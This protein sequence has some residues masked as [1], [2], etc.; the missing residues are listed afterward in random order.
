MELFP[1]RQQE[2]V[3]KIAEITRLI[4]N[5]LEEA[6]PSVWIEGEV[7]KALY[8]SS[9]HLYLTLKEEKD[10][11]DATMWAS[12]RR[13]LKFNV[14]VGMKILLKG[15]ISNYGPYGK[16]QLIAERI[17]PAGIG[18]LQIKFEQLKKK[19]A[20]KGYFEEER[21]KPLPAFPETIGIVTSATGAAFRDMVR[22][23]RRRNPSI[24]I[25][26]APVLVEGEQA[27]SQIA[28][29]ID[30]FNRFGKVDL[31]IAGRGGGSPESL[32]AFNEEVVADA[33]YRSRIPLI[34]AV[35]HE[36]DFTIAD[37]VAD[38]RASTPSAAAELAV[39]NRADLA[40]AVNVQSRRMVS[41]MR[42]M[43]REY[44]HR[45]SGLVRSPVF[46]DPARFLEHDR[47]RVDEN[48]LRIA[49][50]VRRHHGNARKRADALARQLQLL[51][52]SLLIRRKMDHV[53]NLEKQLAQ[54]LG[55]LLGEK[56]RRFAA[57]SG[58]INALSPLKVLERG[59]A[60]ARTPDGKIIK[61][62][63]Q[64]KPGDALEVLLHK[65]SLGVRVEKTK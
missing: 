53:Q 18:A 45:L 42:G 50:A 63:A 34:S 32:W 10:V 39:K 4:K 49:N 23:L 36:I 20:A 48:L 51:R 40:H 22:I 17:E 56:Q 30:D 43:V 46:T 58:S 44:R 28:Q 13:N 29:A 12:S 16:Y 14:E 62:S 21:K 8:H 7:S 64:A 65:G 57:V 60:I 38:L 2:K 37:F 5:L 35:G 55:A 33:I 47:R 27:K 41:A 61:D 31:I 52:P 3:Y 24:K 26:L 6:F 25:I 15:R 1:E 11:L 9:G 19:L 54:K 59:Y